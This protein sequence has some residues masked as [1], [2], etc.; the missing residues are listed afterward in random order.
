MR[1][2]S[3]L[4]KMLEQF[5]IEPERVRLEWISASEGGR[6][7]QVAREMCETIKQLG[8]LVWRKDAVV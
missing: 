5:G 1:R 4:V 2:Y 7:A 8:P 6:F 3:L